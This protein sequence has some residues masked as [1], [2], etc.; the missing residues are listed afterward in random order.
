[1]APV[2]TT[3]EASFH[4]LGLRKVEADFNRPL[5]LR[6]LHAAGIVFLSQQIQIP[7]LS[8]K[9]ADTLRPQKL[10]GGKAG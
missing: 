10:K 6:G 5:E 3:T 2:Y 8:H 7:L 9:Y 4:M 1:M